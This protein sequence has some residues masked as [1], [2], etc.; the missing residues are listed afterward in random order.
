MRYS[1]LAP[2]H[3]ASVHI[4]SLEHASS[5]TAYNSLHPSLDHN[6]LVHRYPQPLTSYYYNNSAGYEDR[7]HGRTR[8]GGQGSGQAM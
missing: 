1:V 6:Q 7:S 8:V 2:A 3:R 5:F 4:R